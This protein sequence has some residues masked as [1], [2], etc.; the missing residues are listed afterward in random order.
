[1]ARLEDEDGKWDVNGGPGW[2]SVISFFLYFCFLFPP[3]VLKQEN[4]KCLVTTLE[5]EPTGFVF[6]SGP[7]IFQNETKKHYMELCSLFSHSLTHAYLFFGDGCS[8]REKK[9][10]KLQVWKPL[11]KSRKAETTPEIKYGSLRT[12]KK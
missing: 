11:W 9:R 3:S 1:M 8:V 12:T 7:H 2:C 10:E 5:S 6:V 4:S